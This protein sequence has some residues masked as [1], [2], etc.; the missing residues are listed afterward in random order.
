[1]NEEK[2]ESTQV[3]RLRTAMRRRQ[4]QEKQELRQTILSAAAGLFLEHG[5]ERFS[6]RQVAERIGYSPTTIYLYFRNKEDLLFTVV[7][8]GFVRFGKQLEAA[9][10][11]VDDPWEQVGALGRAYITFGVENPAYYQM[12]FVQRTD[13]LWQSQEGESQPRLAAF[14]ILRQTVQRAIDANVLRAG[15]A[16][17]YSDL[18][19]AVTHGIVSLAISFPVFDTA[20]VQRLIET[21]NQTLSTGLRSGE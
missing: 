17:D 9:L 21:W 10:I 6:L 8:E 16:D 12:M 11:G 3:E 4:E 14:Q 5:Y 20:R 2:T 15:N 7:E 1:M 19:W 13:F 18:L